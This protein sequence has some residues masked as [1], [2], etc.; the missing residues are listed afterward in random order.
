MTRITGRT[1]PPEVSTG[2]T[3]LGR[4]LATRR[5]ELGLT[6]EAVGRRCGAEASYIAY[7]EEHAAAPEIGTLVRL[8]DA[9]GTTVSELTGAT[10]DTPPGRATARRDTDLV[11]LTDEECRELLSTHGI[12]RIAVVTPDGPA[13]VPVNYVVAGDE[14]AFRTHGEGLLARAAGTE[15]AFETDRIDDAVRRGWSVLAVGEAAGVT[16]AAAVQRLDAVARSLP[17]AG[18]SRRY[19]MTITP[20]RITGRRVVH[21]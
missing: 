21:Q 14:I 19:W 3:D 16:D 17:W 18:G 1:T 4:R 12:G 13:I 6:R 15:V 11:A 8:A 7:L 2:R 10:A 5:V 9:L 20:T